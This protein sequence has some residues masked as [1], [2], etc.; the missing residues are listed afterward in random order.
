MKKILLLGIFDSPY[1]EYFVQNVLLSSGYEVVIIKK[2]GKVNIHLP[3][4]KNLHVI[5]NK[6]PKAVNG[7]QKILRI[8]IRFF[9][10]R[11]YGPY[12]IINI[13]FV[14]IKDLK[15]LQYY[16]KRN[17]KTIL[18]FWGSDILRA[19]PKQLEQM[20]SFI[21]KADLITTDALCTQ[22]AVLKQFTNVKKIET[23]YFGDNICEE[24]DKIID[25][26]QSYR[27]EFSLSDNKIIVAIGY[28]A[29]ETQQHLKVLYE[30]GKMNSNELNNYQFL[31]QFSYCLE[32]SEYIKKVLDYAKEIKI[33]YIVIDNYLTSFELAKLRLSVDIFINSQTTDAFC[34]TVK[35]YLLAKTIILNPSW[36]RYEELD[37]WGLRVLEYKSFEELTS[38]LI[39][40]KELITNKELNNNSSIIKNY[41][42]WDSCKKR[43][44][45]VIE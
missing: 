5:E 35:E 40:Y 10:I 37:K 16:K 4:H 41:V 13:Q 39:N 33:D 6:F 42:G 29:R 19:S 30:I 18:T 7:V 15:R 23:I 34:N 24:I 22:K 1:I 36:L 21:N 12:D 9:E 43:W 14:T 27:K 25:I 11:K 44:Q 28:N 32:D 8:L 3:E 17:T 38:L 20:S 2:N 45:G 31:F 26:A